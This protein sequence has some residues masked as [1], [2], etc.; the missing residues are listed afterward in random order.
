MDRAD[1]QVSAQETASKP[2]W[3][4][5][6]L[7][8]APGLAAVAAAVLAVFWPLASMR[9]LLI[10]GEIVTSDLINAAYPFRLILGRALASGHLPL[11]TDQIYCGY[12]LLA[13]PAV[14]VFY[15]PNWWF[16]V[17]PGPGLAAVDGALGPAPD[18]L[19]EAAIDLM[20]GADAL[21]HRGTPESR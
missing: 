1:Q 4:R 8:E 6:A 13:N 14:G 17:L 16:A 19:A 21:R 18:V 9:G 5:R 3:R 7:R 12:P 20:L 15:P 11:W 2:T 10:T